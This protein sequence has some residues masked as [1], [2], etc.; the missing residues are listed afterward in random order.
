MK[1]AESTREQMGFVLDVFQCY[2]V[3][4]VDEAPQP[5]VT[6]QRKT[7]PHQ[8]PKNFASILWNVFFEAPTCAASVTLDDGYQ[9]PSSHRSHNLRFS[10]FLPHWR[11]ES[12]LRADNT[13]AV[14][15]R[16]L[17]GSL[18]GIMRQN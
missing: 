12:G 17:H 11:R 14:S 7:L 9:Q 18:R 3:K 8:I 13:R 1:E 4:A 5:L 10:R 16:L 2:I 15:A 6:S